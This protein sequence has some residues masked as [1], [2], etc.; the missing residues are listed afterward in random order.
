MRTWQERWAWESSCQVDFDIVGLDCSRSGN[1]NCY[2]RTTKT[3]KSRFQYLHGGSK[4]YSK[5]CFSYFSN[6]KRRTRIESFSVFVIQKTVLRSC[7]ERAL[8][9]SVKKNEKKLLIFIFNY[10]VKNE[11]KIRDL[12]Y[13]CKETKTQYMYVQI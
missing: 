7:T 8:S 11:T 2:V 9:L 13:L 5:N 1:K 10:C 6:L 4:L 12:I 3:R